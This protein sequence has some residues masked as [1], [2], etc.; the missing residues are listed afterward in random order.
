MI[1]FLTLV[2]LCLSYTHILCRKEGRE[3]GVSVAE[4]Q[5]FVAVFQNTYNSAPNTYI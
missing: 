1:M 4:L 2:S 3:C 5:G